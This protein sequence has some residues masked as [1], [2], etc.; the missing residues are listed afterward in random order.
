MQTPHCAGHPDR[1]S[2]SWGAS[3]PQFPSCISAGASRHK[4]RPHHVSKSS[5]E[6]WAPV[7]SM[8]GRIDAQLAS[9]WMCQS[10]RFLVAVSP[11]LKMLPFRSLPS[12]PLL[13]G[14]LLGTILAYSGRILLRRRPCPPQCLWE[15]RREWVCVQT[16]WW[17]WSREAWGLGGSSRGCME[18][19]RDGGRSRFPQ[20]PAG[21]AWTRGTDRLSEEGAGPGGEEPKR[22]LALSQPAAAGPSRTSQLP[23]QSACWRP[24][25][26]LGWG[27]QD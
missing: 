10:Q 15:L 14:K 3:R 12:V 19:R 22:G 5:G 23:A 13:V 2:R 27:S 11:P 25:P 4:Q 16:R 8:K 17:G 18:K 7:P 6:G 26:G 20:I 21:L 1:D 24:W 9:S